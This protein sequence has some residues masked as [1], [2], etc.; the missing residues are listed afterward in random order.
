MSHDKNQVILSDILSD[1]DHAQRLLERVYSYAIDSK[2]TIAENM[3]SCADT[4]ILEAIEAIEA[5]Y[6]LEGLK[7]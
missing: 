5:Q 4:C 6:F 3:L 2:N 1:L 7:K